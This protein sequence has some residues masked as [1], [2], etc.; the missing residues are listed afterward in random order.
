[1]AS[2]NCQWTI[3]EALSDHLLWK[4]LKSPCYYSSSFSFLVTHSSSPSWYMINWFFLVEYT[5]LIRI[6]CAGRSYPYLLTILM[7]LNSTRYHQQWSFFHNNITRFSRKCYII[8]TTSFNKKTDPTIWTL[9]YIYVPIW[10]PIK[11]FV[12]QYCPWSFTLVTLVL[13]C[14]TF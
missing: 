5:C 11:T 4:L 14:K 13:M 9:K 2:P 6:P 12:P 1:M 3:M 7:E 10:F 8:R